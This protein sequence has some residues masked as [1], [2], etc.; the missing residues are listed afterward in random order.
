VRQERA[1]LERYPS[2]NIAPV[3]ELIVR[4]Q[5]PELLPHDWE[6]I[7]VRSSRV[8]FHVGRTLAEAIADAELTT[9]AVW[10][11]DRIIV[12]RLGGPT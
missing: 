10:K 3:R 2:L 8:Q 12:G 1:S 6:D 7:V 5:S 4:A 9:K 11:A